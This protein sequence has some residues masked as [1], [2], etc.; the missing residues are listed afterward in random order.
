MRVLTS[1]TLYASE[2]LVSGFTTNRMQVMP[3]SLMHRIDDA[4]SCIPENKANEDMLRILKSIGK[5]AD[6]CQLYEVDIH[7][8]LHND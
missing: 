2:H 7:Y 6:E 8:K 3:P 4:N 5:L 1:K